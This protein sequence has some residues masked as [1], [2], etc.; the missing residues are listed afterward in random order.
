MVRVISL[1]EEAYSKLKSAKGERSFSETVISLL[2]AKPK[3]D[4]ME[5]A[6]KW[7]GGEAEIMRIGKILEEDRK[8]FRF[9]E[10]EF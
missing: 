2:E 5:F 3:K 1:S 7:P 10:V 6:G 9:R 8:K 4:I